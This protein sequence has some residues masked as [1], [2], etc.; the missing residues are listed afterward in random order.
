M[1]APNTG[2]Y[3]GFRNGTKVT[4]IMEGQGGQ[5]HS[6]YPGMLGSVAFK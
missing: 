2:G 3:V 4:L 5:R 1:I 6:R